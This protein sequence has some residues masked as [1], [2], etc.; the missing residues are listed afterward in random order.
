MQDFFLKVVRME[1][2]IVLFI[3]LLIL[4]IA[5]WN[6]AFNNRTFLTSPVIS[7]TMPDGPFDY[8]G[9]KSH[10]GIWLDPGASAW[11]LEPLTKKVVN[12]YKS[13]RIPL[14]NPNFASGAPLAANMQSASFFPLRALFLISTSALMWDVYIFLRYILAAYISYLFLRTIGLRIISSLTGALIFALSGY[15]VLYYNMGH[16]DVDILVPLALL[17]FEKLYR[18]K[19]LCSLIF[20]AL[21]VALVIL[22]GMPESSLFVLLFA[23]LYY[24]YRVIF[25]KSVVNEKASWKYY[26]L[27]FIL[28]CIL[29]G[30]IALPQIIPFLEYLSLSYNS[31]SGKIVGIS[32][33]PIKGIASLISPYFY[34]YIY[35][36][37]NDLRS[38]S[39]VGYIGVIPFI[40]ASVALTNKDSN[41]KF[42]YFFLGWATFFFLKFYGFPLINWIGYLPLLN[43]CIFEK[44]ACPEFIF[45]IAYLAARGFENVIVAK[46]KKNHLILGVGFVFAIVITA[47]L[48]NYPSILKNINYVLLNICI[49]TFLSIICILIILSDWTKVNKLKSGI[50]LTSIVFLLILIL[51]L[52]IYNQK[53]V[54]V[55][56]ITLRNTMISIGLLLILFI[57]IY[58]IIKIWR[59][60]IQLNIILLL[61]LVVFELFLYI[62]NDRSERGEIYKM[63]PFVKFI[64]QDP[65]KFRI[66]SK[67]GYLFPNTSSAYNIDDIRVN[68]AMYIR[69]YMEFLKNLVS[70]KIYD[71][72]DGP[73]I[74]NIQKVGKYLNLLNVKYILATEDINSENLI[75]TIL[76]NSKCISDYPIDESTFVINSMAKKVLFQHPPSKLFYPLQVNNGETLDFC[77]AIRQEAWNNTD[78]VEFR[79]FARE[80]SEDT[81]FNKL[82][83]PKNNTNDQKWNDYTVNLE[84]YKGQE[85]D[86]NFVTKPLKQNEYDWAHWSSPSI[87]PIKLDLA[88]AVSSNP[89]REN[90]GYVNISTLNISG[91]VRNTLF[92]HPPS[93]VTLSVKIPEDNPTLEFGIALDP[94]VWSPTKGDGVEFAITVS[95][96]LGEELL[97]SK[98]L[99]P[100][101]DASCRNWVH[102][103]IEMSKYKGKNIDLVLM[104][105][106][107]KNNAYDWAGWD[108]RL[109]SSKVKRY[110]LVY[111]K[112]IKIFENKNML[113]RAYIVH[114]AEVI[115]YKDNILNR[116]KNDKFDFKNTI[117]IEKDPQTASMLTGYNAPTI[118]NSI[119][120]I[121]NYQ[122]DK[123]SFKVN[124]ENAGY[125]VVGDSYYPGWKVLVNG[126]EK[127]ILTANY[128]YRAVFLDKGTYDVQ[129][130][131]RPNSFWMSSWV[132]GSTLLFIMVS[133]VI[134]TKILKKHPEI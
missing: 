43:V 66:F 71:R 26:V 67:E 54:K 119:A 101:N 97:L 72:F 53:I 106:P 27:R 44:Y 12:E 36:T 104:T 5:F 113:P 114:R 61:L 102:E 55:F 83:D 68:E 112:E 133:L 62:P 109:N 99:D 15:F 60:P 85:V 1:K 65:E 29:G 51:T 8:E 40:L 13:R 98:Y 80:K 28:V 126:K 69:R 132:S 11:Q 23:S 17:A 86:L 59:K 14:W 57:T 58:I 121:L 21:V 111:D 117:I 127:E 52:I 120:T 2:V 32:Y 129:F 19:N 123:V 25:N 77:L 110:D 107:G 87:G 96:T 73:E 9:E 18:S 49:L 125:L 33:N 20:S 46:I 42:N 82:I 124:M 4:T 30:L 3:I 74:D 64:K 48:L 93:K 38:N 91:D 94:N 131:Y 88:K 122:S 90:K 35:N 63:P 24:F 41:R 116:L 81:I 100:A 84:K 115:K 108:V 7:S 6:V 10:T 79:V 103:S 75:K 50:I 16:I 118:D 76:T 47:I 89:N 45:C 130:I 37:W 92:E 105:L 39:L 95:K 34:G 78:G 31:H 70:N 56:N 22:G 134:S 128:I